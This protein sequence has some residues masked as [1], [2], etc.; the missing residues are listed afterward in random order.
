MY[1]DPRLNKLY[2]VQLE[3]KDYIVEKK[4]GQPLKSYEDY[5][6]HPEKYESNFHQSVK[7]NLLLISLDS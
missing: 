3:V 4:G 1:L 6:H 5:L 7:K 2:G